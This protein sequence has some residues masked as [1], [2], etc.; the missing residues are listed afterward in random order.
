MGI[1]LL[2]FISKR[3]LNI[4]LNIIASDL[5]PAS[6][7]VAR[8]GSYPESITTVLKPNLLARYFIRSQ[9]GRFVVRKQLREQ[10]MFSQHNLI[11][12]PHFLISTLSAAAIC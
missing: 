4:K 1:A 10:I 5:D 9:T 3:G 11:A 12:D 7:E 2:E 8:S 6:L